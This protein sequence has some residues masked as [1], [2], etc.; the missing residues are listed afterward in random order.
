MDKLEEQITKILSLDQCIEILIPFKLTTYFYEGKIKIRYE[1]AELEFDVLIPI[2]YPLTMPNSD[3]I[4][5]KF[6]NEDLIG[7]SHINYDGS[8]CFHPEKDDNFERKLKS[9]IEGLKLW[10][11][12]YYISKKEDDNYTYLIHDLEFSKISTLYFADNDKKFRKDDFG[13]FQ[14]ANFSNDN[15]ETKGL[16]TKEENQTFFRIGF[17]RNFEDKWSTDFLNKLK[18]IQNNGFWIY[19]EREP[20]TN[21]FGKRKSI[22]TWD[23]LEEYLSKAFIRNLYD[24]FK[25]LNKSFFFEGDLFILIGYKIPNNEQYEIHWDLI[26]I[27]QGK[28]PIKTIL[29]PIED[30][31]STG[32]KYIGICSTDKIIWGIT[33]N[34]NYN[35]FFGRGKLSQNIIN[36]RILIIGCGALGS[37]LSEIL[38]RGGCKKL[39]LDDFD[40]VASGNLCR[41][42]YKLSSL[43]SL[44]IDSLKKNLINISPF[45]DIFNIPLKLSHYSNTEDWLNSNVDFVFDCSTDSEVTYIFDKINFKGSVFSLSITNKA[46]E[47][48]CVTG[49]NITLKNN[50]FYNFL[51][52]EE[53]TFLEG[54]GCGYPTFEANLNDISSLLNLAMLNI[55]EQIEKSSVLDNFI[56]SK[57]F[58]KGFTNLKI[59]GFDVFYEE[60]ME[61]YLYI[62]NEVLYKIKEQLLY[63]YPKEFGGVFI[64][65]KDRNLIIIQD[66]LIPDHFE[67]GKT[68]F[69]RHPGTL[70]D[71]LELI[72]NETEGRTSYI[73]EWHSHPNSLA[74][75]SHTDINAMEEIAK[76]EKTGN[77]N[78]V[79]MIVKITEDIFEPIVYIYNKEKL[80]KYE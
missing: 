46:K 10:I 58:E 75:P 15:F 23:Q 56:I 39:V 67:N 11:Y 17:D 24:S 65:F 44:K 31:I 61:E 6:R 60:S 26:K 34:C 40:Y 66:I 8:V 33:T 18:T 57:V 19:I 25:K 22:N 20:I 49:K 76:D 71:R 77:P 50:H 1:G 3:N 12:N 32:D 47:L 73:G 45:V 16:K 5:I 54:T 21:D 41:S 74:N 27:H 55:N 14:Y 2:I 37:L 38:V 30:R 70:N 42:N 7:Y 36:S 51:G 62:S 69:V 80:F 63:H 28:L 35:R 52:N 29:V 48:V 78:P 43:S 9:E 64:G 68:L 4:S 53:P 13:T 59:Q 79:L 72:F